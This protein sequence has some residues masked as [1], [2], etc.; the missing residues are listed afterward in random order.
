MNISMRWLLPLLLL[1]AC[2]TKSEEIGATVGESSGSDST[3]QS[4]TSDGETGEETT[5]GLTIVP[6]EFTDDKEAC[7]SA[8]FGPDSLER[9]AWVETAVTD[10]T[11]S[12]DPEPQ[13]QCITVQYQGEG[14]AISPC[15]GS[16]SVYQ[17]GDGDAPVVWFASDAFCEYQPVGFTQCVYDG[18]GE[19]ALGCDCICE[20]IGGVVPGS[21]CDPLGEACPDTT[22]TTQE[23]EPNLQNDGWACVPQYAGTSPQYGDECWPED[24]PTVACTGETICLPAEGL[25]VAGCDGGEGGGCCTQLCD[26]TLGGEGSCPDEGQVCSQFYEGQ[27]PA[28]Y[29][30]VGVCRLP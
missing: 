1:A 10:G 20:G 26:L 23:C 30:H 16:T 15:V 3:A 6:C 2:D 5:G 28:G 29:E 17:M 4:E 24:S 22:E 7:E 19:S 21:A 12:N 25:G 9:C 18:A 14:C 11:C 8:D 27:P 13:G